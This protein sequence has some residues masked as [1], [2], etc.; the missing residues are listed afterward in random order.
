MKAILQALWGPPGLILLGV[1]LSAIGALWASQQ[2]GIFERELRIKSDEIAKL[3][4]EIVKSVIGGDS[5]CYL[6]IASLDPHSNSG[7]LTIIHQGDHPIYDISA[8]MADLQKMRAIEKGEK[9]K[10]DFREVMQANT[11]IPIGNMAKGTATAIGPFQLG[12]GTERNFNIFFNAR[13]GFFTQLLRL[14]KINNKWVH[15]TK[16][17]KDGK[18]IFEKIDSDFP[19]NSDATFSW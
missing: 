4:K 19:R 11:N 13:N 15:A 7:I 18:I 10:I 2:K 9:G 16:V 12:T 14:K 5:F 6:M 1:I 8:R 3:N 17:E